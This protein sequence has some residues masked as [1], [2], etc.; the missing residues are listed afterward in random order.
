MHAPLRLLLAT[1]L[2]LAPGLHPGWAQGAPSAE[3][4]KK[5]TDP[6]AGLSLAGL[7]ARSLGPAVN[8]G[9]VIGFAV[10]PRNRARYYAAAAS[11]GVWKTE[12]NG[13]T[14]S[15]VF[16]QE[17]AFSIGAV[18]LDPQNPDTVW[19]G[20]GERNSQRSVG[21]GDG[22]YRS[23]DGGK[24]WR[25]V[26][27]KTSEHIGRIVVD[28]RNGDVVYVAAAGPLW[29]AGGERGLYKTTD[30]GK[31]WK[32]VLTVDEH[33]GVV[34]VAQDPARPEVLYAATWQRR[35]HFHTLINGG[36]GSALYRSTDGGATWTKLKGG[37]PA[38]DLGRIGVTVSPVDPAVVYATVEAAGTGSGI[39]RSKDRGLTWERTN[40]AIS[41][42]MYYGQIVADPRNVDRIY[43][44][45]VIFQV[46]DDG[47]RTKRP[48]GERQKHVD[49][50][51]IWVDPADPDYLRVGCD[52]GIYESHDRGAHWHFKANLPITQF[53]DVTTD[54]GW[55]FYHVYG[56]TQDNGSLGGPGRTR[57]ASGIPNAE[58]FLTNGGDGFRSQVHPKAPDTIFAESQNG[59]LVR[60]D[61]RT[62][63]RVSI[64]PIPG[65]GEASERYNWD[66]PLLVSPHDPNRLYF[67]GHRLF[68]SDNRGDDWKT[69]TG[70]LS[71]GLDRNALPV[72]GKIWGPDAVAKHQST[73]LYGNASALSESPLQ[74]GLLYVG[75][76]DGLLHVSEDGGATWRKVERVT[77]VPELAYV[78]RVLASRHDVNTVYAV[79]N[80]HQ[81][82]DFKPY[83]MRSV[84]RG[85]TWTS[86]S[87]S[88]PERGSTY[89]V[90]EDA[91]NPKLLFCGTEFGLFFSV[92]GGAKWV[93]L[94]AGLP[95]IAVRDLALHDRAGDLIVGTFGRGIYVIDDIS[96]LRHLRAETLG[97]A[98]ELFPVP[99]G[100]MHV[101]ATSVV[102]SQGASHFAAANPP[103]GVPI[104]FWLKEVPKTRKQRRQE[105]EKKGQAPA[106]PTL[107]QLRQ[108]QEEEAPTV[109][110]AISD[111]EGR[112]VRRLSAPATVGLQRLVWDFR[113]AP[114]TLQ[115]TPPSPFGDDDDGP[116]SQGIPV[117]PGRYTARLALVVDGVPRELGEARAFTVAAEGV[118]DLPEADR[119]ALATFQRRVADLQRTVT[120]V[121]DAA[122]TARTRVGLM[123]K[124]AA[125]APGAQPA[126]LAEVRALDLELAEV[127]HLVRGGREDVDNPPPSLAQ[128]VGTVAS[129]IRLSSRR[130]ADSLRAQADLAAETLASARTRLK[131]VLE[132]RLPKLE[133]DLDA[134]GAPWTPGRVP[135][136]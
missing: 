105:A 109:Q 33:T 13:T 43:I 54:Q 9:R 133:R 104:S 35:R 40:P 4:P 59:G 111:A 117:M 75:T 118:E 92:D 44:P 116:R 91:V 25:N 132:V 78:H 58:W 122:T 96:P 66:S 2:G 10:D 98:A 64:S 67:G 74:E 101:R 70:D 107:A 114:T 48:L 32:A 130:P 52:G 77:G 19:V 1:G 95:T 63:E 124:A 65:K 85:R 108:E 112:V 87:A 14:W 86:L 39:Y 127:I 46:S 103:Y 115:P 71:R 97:A 12:N 125:E 53:Y 123:R 31:T 8:S 129:R 69:L 20:T 36:P 42:G 90:V 3:A 99:E 15:P 82:G 26:G 106:Y 89:A 28:P 61:R 128:R 45:D 41:Q 18:A 62:G 113:Q 79:F 50:H 6:W 134:A 21:Y 81:A 17:G 102:G 131:Q 83:L 34:D 55:P 84:D 73:A 88:L 27:L 24:T 120:A 94:K 16:E 121:G 47:G 30:G 5:P 56:G 29:S 126:L 100:L 37:L 22:V 110:V 80:N 93:P 51:A 57:Q 76:D 23:D 49:N 38:G 136:L 7:K 68:R 135:S 119:Q 11:G 60:F 72:M